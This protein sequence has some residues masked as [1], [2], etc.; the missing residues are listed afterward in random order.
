MSVKDINRE[1]ERKFKTNKKL[2]LSK[3]VR[4]IDIKQ[5]YFSYNPALRIRIID[6]KIAELT[7]KRG[8]I[9][10]NEI[11]TIDGARGMISNILKDVVIHKTRHHIIFDGQK[12]EV[13][14]FH[15]YYAGLIIAEIE[16]PSPEE[17]ENIKLPD[18]VDEEI[19]SNRD[20][21]N[22]N[23]YKRMIDEY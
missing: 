17:L 8:T 11:I 16:Q 19:T 14:V 9:E 4:A 10:Q 3:S 22:S 5:A 21:R 20:Y 15:G 18:W 2:D 12:W 6:D 1:Y 7:G 13:D 23:M